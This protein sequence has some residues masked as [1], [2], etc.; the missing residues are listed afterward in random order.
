M[1]QGTGERVEALM[2]DERLG[3]LAGQLEEGLI[4]I[5]YCEVRVGDDHA[6]GHDVKYAFPWGGR[7]LWIYQPGGG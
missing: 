1:A 5:T 6:F 7:S 4:D 3:G 2:P